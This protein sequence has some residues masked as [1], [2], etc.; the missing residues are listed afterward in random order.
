MHVH[1]PTHI[2][3]TESACCHSLLTNG[4]HYTSFKET[5][6]QETAMICSVTASF[7]STHTQSCCG[8]CQSTNVL[9]ENLHRQPPKTS[10]KVQAGLGTNILQSS[11]FWISHVKHQAPLKCSGLHQR[12]GSSSPYTGD[13]KSTSTALPATTVRTSNKEK[14]NKPNSRGKWCLCCY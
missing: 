3:C 11:E 13:W 9:H 14:T 1:I 10:S 12:Y 5:T 4:P 2:Y 6:S 7:C 8:K